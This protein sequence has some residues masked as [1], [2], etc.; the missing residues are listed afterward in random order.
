[1]EKTGVMT[2]ERQAD[3]TTRFK[4]HEGDITAFPVDGVVSAVNHFL[5]G[6]G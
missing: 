6:G 2:K 1:M 4:I 3:M 5:L